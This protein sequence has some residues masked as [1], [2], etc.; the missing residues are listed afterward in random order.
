MRRDDTL[1]A[2]ARILTTEQD[3]TEALR[4]VARTVAAFVGADTVAVYGLDRARRLL[5]PVAAYHV[6]KDIL[7]HLVAA[8]VPIDEQGFRDSVFGAAGVTWSDDVSRDPRFAFGLFRAFP[9]R[10]GVVVPIHLDTDVAGA[11]Y[12]VW[13]ERARVI[14]PGLTDVLL[15]IGQQIALLLR[16]AGALQQAQRDAADAVAA[17]ERYRTLVERVP[18]GIYR[19]TPDG[20]ILDANQ[21]MV[22]ILRFPSREALLG[23]NARALWVNAGERRQDSGMRDVETELRT[24]DGG[25]VWVRLRSRAMRDGEQEYWEGV[26][27][28]ITD[29]RRAEDAERRA[30]ALRAVA[31]LANAA[32]HEIN[33]PLVVITGRLELL[34]RHIADPEAL[35]RFEPALAACRRIADIIAHMGRLTRLE[36]IDGVSPMLDL[37]ASAPASDAGTGEGDGPR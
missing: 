16:A 5:L 8:T 2:I 1:V 6:P 22:A 9:H 13:W 10:S 7:P 21:A 14:E 37:R 26:L 19:S 18:I 20:T 34:R 36:T 12:L 24:G 27:E 23:I 30:E 17:R 28:D 3:V 11:L 31:L 35:A 15:A 33:N 4:Q 25:T 29:R 32:A